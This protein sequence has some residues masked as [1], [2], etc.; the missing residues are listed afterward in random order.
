MNQKERRKEKGKECKEDRKKTESEIKLKE[1]MKETK[2][3]EN[4]IMPA[5][6]G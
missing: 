5:T 1:A 4:Y 3:G 2:G 6:P